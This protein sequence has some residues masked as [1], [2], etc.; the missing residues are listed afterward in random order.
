MFLFILFIFARDISKR[1][2]FQTIQK[3]QTNIID[4]MLRNNSVDVM[5]EANLA[6]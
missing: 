4:G 2:L 5:S 6:C 1:V 3:V